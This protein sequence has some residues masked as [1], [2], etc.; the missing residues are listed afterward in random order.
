MEKNQEKLKKMMFEGE[1]LKR[2]KKGKEFNYDGE[3][4][5]EGEY[6]NGKRWNGKGKEYYDNNKIKFPFS[7]NS[8]PFPF[9]SPFKYSPS[10][11]KNI[12]LLV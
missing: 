6:L 12:L 2:E 3:L 5:F 8:F 10:Y 9:L 7:S 11:I 1:Y 4:I